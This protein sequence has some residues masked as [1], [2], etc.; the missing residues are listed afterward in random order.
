MKSL[1]DFALNE[2]YKHIQKL[3]D[4]LA[5]LDTLVDWEAFR[6]IVN[7]LYHSNS[8]QGG[9]PNTDEVLLVKMVVL[10]SLYGLT[11]PE[12]ERQAN[13]RISFRKF[14]VFP[15]NIPGFTT[16]WYFRERLIEAGKEQEI[17][18]QLQHQLDAKGM[19]I[20]RG[21]I[22]D[23]TF[24]TADPGH[25][26]SD[27][28]RD[29]EVKTR[30]SREGTWA[31]KG[32][33][34]F[35][36]YKLHILMDKDHQLIRRLDTT[37]ASTHDSQID[38]SQSGETVYRDKG[39]FGVKPSASMDKTMHRSTRGHPLSIKEKRRNKAISRT[40]SLVERPFAVI[41]RGFHAGHVMVTTIARTH[42]KNL[43][44]CFAF[45]LNQLL[46]IDKLSS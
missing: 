11:D 43:F 32:D 15:D 46:T 30:R 16:I 44:S 22:Q 40:R 36:G 37:T 24:I 9:R 38:L 7:Q 33:K 3:G 35:F 12:L 45:D 2:E 5:E 29:E 17:L 26:S 13:D 6:P 14:L 19:K 39:Y 10:Q 1:T 27:T 42:V 20:K 34:S 4:K 25:S 31:K 8:V 21:V 41:K 23:A 28:P 18:D